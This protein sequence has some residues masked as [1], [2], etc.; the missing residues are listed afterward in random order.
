[1]SIS[2]TI[3]N[4]MT[5]Y[6]PVR[7]LNEDKKKIYND[8]LKNKLVS[9]LCELIKLDNLEIKG[10]T[11]VS[12]W[13]DIPWIGIGDSRIDSKPTTGVYIA[14]LFRADGKQVSLS[15]QHGTDKLKIKEIKSRVALLRNNK[16]LKSD[17][18]NNSDLKIKQPKYELG[19]NLSQ[20]AGKYEIANILGKTYSKENIKDIEEDIL[21]IIKIYIKW[22]EST[23]YKDNYQVRYILNEEDEEYL[24]NKKY[25]KY[26]NVYKIAR[27]SKQVDIALKKSGYICEIDEKH[28]TFVKDNGEVYLE[29]HHLI[30]M[31][32]YSEFENSIDSYINIYTLCPLCHRKIHYAKKE[33]RFKMIEF[34]YNKRKDLYDKYYHISLEKMKLY[35]N[36][37]LIEE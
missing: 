1:M 11:R 23:L 8:L 20:R 19:F 18:F 17:K 36:K 2:K 25:I 32:F 7:N 33:E 15:I 12:K 22:V 31:E 35:Y 4:I 10:H 5:N 34:L 37:E 27:D 14:I 13:A 24:T 26:T 30:P 9:Q 21:D 28:E 16:Y 6:M 29:S 3:N